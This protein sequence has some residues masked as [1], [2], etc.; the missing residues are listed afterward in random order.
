MRYSLRKGVLDKVPEIEI[1]EKEYD[2]FSQARN[3]LLNALAIE[4]KYDIL[5]ANYLDFEKE[6]LDTT[7][8]YRKGGHPIIPLSREK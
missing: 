6:I 7:A 4:E 3:I 2:A 5:I 1:T 8:I